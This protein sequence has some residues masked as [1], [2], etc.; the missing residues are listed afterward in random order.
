MSNFTDDFK[1]VLLAGVGAVATTAE[2]SKEVIQTLMEKGQITA[3][4]GKVLLDEMAEKGKQTMEQS[5]IKNEELKRNIKDKIREKV[6]SDEITADDVMDFLEKVSPEE[7]QR[8]KDKL[9]DVEEK[10]QDDGS[11]GT[12]EPQNGEN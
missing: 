1:K 11:H 5:K 12:D 4:Q 9:S 7:L 6:G 10:G 2:K 3:Q 8:I